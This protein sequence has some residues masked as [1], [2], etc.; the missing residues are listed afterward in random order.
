M[1]DMNKEEIKS[2]NP[3]WASWTSQSSEPI[4]E[5]TVMTFVKAVLGR[6]VTKAIMDTTEMRVLQSFIDVLVHK[7]VPRSHHYQKVIDIIVMTGSS[8]TSELS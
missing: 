2:S 6:T 3:P 1:K 8:H 5:I 4:M 7:E